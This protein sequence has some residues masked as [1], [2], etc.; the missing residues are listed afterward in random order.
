M[1]VDIPKTLID[2]GGWVF[3]SAVLLGVIIAVI[4]GELVTGSAFKREV[5]RGD[6]LEARLEKWAEFGESLTAQVKIL[7]ELVADVLRPRSK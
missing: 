6:K 4:R 3:A 2:A 7:T 5:E 1:P